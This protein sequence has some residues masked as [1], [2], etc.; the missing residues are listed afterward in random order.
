MCMQ[1]RNVKTNCCIISFPIGICL[2]LLLL[3]VSINVIFSGSD[4]K[5][6]CACVPFTDGRPGC[7]N[8]CGIEYSTETQASFCAIEQ[9]PR[10]PALLQLPAPPYRAVQQP[11]TDFEDGLPTASCR[12]TRSCP[13]TFLYTGSNR[14]FAEGLLS[15]IRKLYVFLCL[16][17]RSISGL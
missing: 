2:F 8:K 15:R 11:N 1:K 6:G 10:W 7:E 3:Q 4:F 12:D 5:C 9:P 17:C 14:S 13:V 16:C